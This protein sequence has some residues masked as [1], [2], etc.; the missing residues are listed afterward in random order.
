MQDVM[1]RAL[2]IVDCTV[3]V[4]HR[5]EAEQREAFRTGHS[6]LDWPDSKHNR[7]PSLAIDIAPY[8][9]DWQD[10][11]RFTLFAGV[12]LGVADMMSIK[13]RW[14]GDWDRDFEVTDN[15]F[16]DLVHFELVE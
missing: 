15:G 10:R 8:P 3:L 13:M 4:G 16:D 9:I 7:Q 1:T 14:G 5:S 6:Q 2:K 12:V 11:E